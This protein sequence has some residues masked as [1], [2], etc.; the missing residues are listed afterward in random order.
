MLLLRRFLLGNRRRLQ[1]TVPKKRISCTAYFT[2]SGIQRQAARAIQRS[3]MPTMAPSITYSTVAHL[4][5][6]SYVMVAVGQADPHDLGKLR[7]S[8]PYCSRGP[9]C[10]FRYTATVSGQL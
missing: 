8:A 6:S 4:L 9:V 3:E 2:V 5:L 10:V 7:S 1:D